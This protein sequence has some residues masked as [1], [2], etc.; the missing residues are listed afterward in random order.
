[1]SHIHSKL[2]ITQSTSWHNQQLGIR[3][4]QLY[5]YTHIQLGSATTNWEFTLTNQNLTNCNSTSNLTPNT[6][7]LTPIKSTFTHTHTHTQL[8]LHIHLQQLY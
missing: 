4:T 2:A 8:E 7:N 3:L 6:L 1:M 5:T